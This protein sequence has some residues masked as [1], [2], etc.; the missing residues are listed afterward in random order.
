MVDVSTYKRIAIIS[1]VGTVEGQSNSYQQKTS[2]SS[3]ADGVTGV[4]N[5]VMLSKGF[6]VVERSDFDTVLKEQ[7]FQSDWGGDSTRR[8]AEIGKALNVPAILIVRVSRASWR[9]RYGYNPSTGTTLPDIDVNT[10]ISAKLVDVERAA[11]VWQAT[12]AGEQ[13]GSNAD[14]FQSVIEI[15]ARGVANA[16][17]T[18]DPNAAA[19]P[20]QPPAKP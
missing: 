10:S 15:C 13:P 11:I 3:I 20:P 18:L 19:L 1:S 6:S 5:E 8:A 17:P 14:A 4:F 2:A 9:Q 12:Y 16:F 7:K